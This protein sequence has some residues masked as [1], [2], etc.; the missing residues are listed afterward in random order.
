M[1]PI[2]IDQMA[3]AMYYRVGRQHERA[4]WES[5]AEYHRE[6]YRSMAIAAAEVVDEPSTFISF[7]AGDWLVR[8]PPE[9]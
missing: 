3:Q 7:K 5:A 1:E 8:Y 2:L 6:V 4:T 9:G